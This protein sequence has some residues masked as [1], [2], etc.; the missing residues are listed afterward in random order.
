MA[1]SQHTIPA[2]LVSRINQLAQR[3]PRPQ[4]V[5]AEDKAALVARIKQLLKQRN[6]QIV[7]HYYVDAELQALAEET[8]GIVADSLEMANF[9][10]QSDA[11]VLVV[12]GVRFMGETAKMLSPEKTVVMPNLDA[13]CSLDV[14]CPADKFAEFCAN[15]PERTVVVYANTSVEVKAIADWVVTSGNALQIVSHLKA[16]GEK[17]IWAPDQHLGAWI[18]KE[19]GIDMLRWMGHCIVHDEFKAFELEALKRQHPD[20]KVL[21]HPESAEAVVALADVVGSTKVLIN[22]V[23]TLP[24]KK[25]IVATDHGIF[26]KMR[27]LA[28][29]K[30]L[31]V[32]P[33][34]SKTTQCISCAHCPWMAM[35]GLQNLADVLENLDQEIE[36]EEPIRLKALQS[37]DRML[38]FSRAHGLVKTKTS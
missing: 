11:E 3:A 21:V 31:I 33:T 20:A 38:E 4:P 30:Q 25:F 15:H 37:V 26:Y 32:A 7:A 34:D 24:D 22:A 29:E 2:E 23:Q 36:I 19:T 17:I 6:A 27:Q 16:R 13:T 28:P 1:A 5:S 10:A 12:C 8:G 9:G 14:G 18:E 35:N